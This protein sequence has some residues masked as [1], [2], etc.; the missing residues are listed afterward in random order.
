VVEQAD[1]VLEACMV[2]ELVGVSVPAEVVAIVAH[3]ESPLER[4]VQLA[5]SVVAVEDPDQVLCRTLGL[6]REGSFRRLHTSTLGP[7]V[8]L[9][10]FDVEGTSLASSQVVVC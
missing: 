1:T 9:A 8:I 3:A 7:V 4:S 5:G 10:R 2:A 6:A